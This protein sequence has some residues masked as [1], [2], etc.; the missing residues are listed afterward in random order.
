MSEGSP[1]PIQFPNKYRIEASTTMPGVSLAN[2]KSRYRCTPQR[3]ANYDAGSILLTRG[4]ASPGLAHCVSRLGR[5]EQHGTR[6]QCSCD[7]A[8]HLHV[9]GELSGK[10]FVS[11]LLPPC[12]RPLVS[13]VTMLPTPHGA[14]SSAAYVAY[15]PCYRPAFRRAC[16]FLSMP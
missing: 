8:L 9:A 10:L 14:F 3:S 15:C 12:R 4:V 1:E 6:L 2:R 11:H 13:A 16:R 5:T 7:A